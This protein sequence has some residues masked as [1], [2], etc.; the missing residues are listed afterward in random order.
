M[1]SRK[2]VL[3]A[4]ITLFGLL[5]CANVAAQ[6][7]PLPTGTVSV[8]SGTPASG[9]PISDGWLS[10]VTCQHATVTCPG[11][12]GSAPLGITFGYKTPSPANGTIV[13]FSH[14]G[15]TTPEAFPGNEGTIASA[16]YNANYQVVQTKWDSDWE[17][18]SSTGAGGSIG[19][20]ACRPATFIAWVVGNLYSALHTANSNAGM[21]LHG[22]SAGGIRCRICACLVWA[23]RQHRQ[24]NDGF[25]PSDGRYRGGLHRTSRL[26][27]RSALPVN[28]G[29]VHITV[30]PHGAKLR[31]IRTRSRACAP[32]RETALPT[33][34]ERAVPRTPRAPAAPRIQRGKR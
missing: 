20:A 17:D 25:R 14:S 3:C 34:G 21:C 5:L 32:G 30:P 29:A 6:S 9:C 7:G 1:I 24:G 2:P 28:L 23:L 22:T 4:M 27:F 12:N 26:S 15:G 31:S 18:E 33:T 11:S 10:G 19:L 8:D 16:Y 13:I